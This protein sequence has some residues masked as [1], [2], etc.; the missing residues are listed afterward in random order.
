[1][2]RDREEKEAEEKDRDEVEHFRNMTEEERRQEL[3]NNP[4]Q[5]TNKASK[6]KYKFMQK[7]YHRGAFFMANEASKSQWSEQ[8]RRSQP[9]H[10]FA[11]KSVQTRLFCCYFGG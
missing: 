5:I 1:M 2:K 10:Y 9:M 7:Y 11:G 4:K 8:F 3:K 6:G